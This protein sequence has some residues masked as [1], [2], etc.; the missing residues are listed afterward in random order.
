MSHAKNLHE[1]AV[2]FNKLLSDVQK[3]VTITIALNDL[4][5]LKKAGY[6]LCFA[7]KVGNNDYNVVWHSYLTYLH[8]NTFSWTPQ[9][10]LF[11]SN[12]FKNNIQLIVSTNTVPIG[13]GETSI[14]NQYGVLKKPTTGGTHKGFTMD[15]RYGRIHPGVRQLSMG[16]DGETVS[17]PIYVSENPIVKGKT[18]LE[19]VDRILVWF[20]QN[21]ETGTMF[22]TSR[23][24]QVEIDL[25]DENTASRKYK[26]QKWVKS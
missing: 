16:I 17:K 12:F 7:K 21:I 6:K 19:P 24:R 23:S 14:L 26:N 3:K 8:N 13:P 18:V 22:N 20:E 2:T 11:G 5:N 15:N 9:Y 1:L 4:E 10:A 25:T